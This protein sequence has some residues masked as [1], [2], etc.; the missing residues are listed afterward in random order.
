VPTLEIIDLS[1]V[2][3]DG[4]NYGRFTN[5][6]WNCGPQPDGF[7]S[8]LFDAVQ[9]WVDERD[10]L[11]AAALAAA[12]QAGDDAVAAALAARDAAYAAD[13][14]IVRTAYEKQVAM[15]QASLA[16]LQA[17]IADQTA[18]I[19]ALGGTELGQQLAREAARRRLLV[20]QERIAASLAALD[21]GDS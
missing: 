3:V 12:T 18:Q 8:Q 5:L 7:A 2:K 13:S 9:A 10:R 17:T 20:A 19:E 21:G 1:N 11:H 15:L 14:E 4:E 16:P 6:Q